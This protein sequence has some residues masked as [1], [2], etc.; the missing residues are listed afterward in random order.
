MEIYLTGCYQNPKLGQKSSEER[1][2]YTLS[3][4]FFALVR[5]LIDNSVVRKTVYDELVQ[6][7]KAIHVTDF[8]KVV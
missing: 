2:F 6:K 1:G 3:Q 7:V 4:I 8:S 5:C